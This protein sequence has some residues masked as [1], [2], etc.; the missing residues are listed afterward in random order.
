MD[1]HEKDIAFRTDPGMG[2]EQSNGQLKVISEIMA[3]LEN[4]SDR[5]KGMESLLM[6]IFER[7]ESDVDK[8][9][10]A[11]ISTLYKIEAKVDNL[12]RIFEL[13]SNSEKRKI[14]IEKNDYSKRA[15]KQ[16]LKGRKEREMANTII[17]LKKNLLKAKD[18]IFIKINT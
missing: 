11:Q 10:L 7:Y 15:R 18:V 8:N 16:D 4:L 9:G 2:S 14:N 3:F 5:V 17:M 12:H 13:A 1:E 6:M